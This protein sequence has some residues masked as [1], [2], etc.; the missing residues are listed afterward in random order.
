MS[1]MVSSSFPAIEAHRSAH[2]ASQSRSVVLRDDMIEAGFAILR[3]HELD[4]LHIREIASKCGVSVGAFYKRFTNKDG[5]LRVLQT[6]VVNEAGQKAEQCFAD[7]RVADL[8][9]HQCINN[10]VGFMIELFSGPSRGVIRA[11]YR[12]AG[13]DI[14]TWEPMRQSSRLIRE[15]FTQMILPKLRSPGP[16]TREHVQF[17]YQLVNGLRINDLLN[18]WHVYGPNSPRLKPELVRLIH[19]Y[20]EAEQLPSAPSQSASNHSQTVNSGNSHD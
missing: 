11:S 7:H 19:L 2:P 6:V 15:Q 12:G 5:F 20:L 8:D 17:V 10:F 3:D 1:Q 9:L 14:D 13:N 4:S 18:P 16:G